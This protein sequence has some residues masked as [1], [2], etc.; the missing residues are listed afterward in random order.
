[1]KIDFTI[2]ETSPAVSLPTFVDGLPQQIQIPLG[3]PF[4]N[5]KDVVHEVIVLDGE[6]R[7]IKF[8]I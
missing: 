7:G 1:M 8:N 5:V 6:L 4:E 2:F 3:V